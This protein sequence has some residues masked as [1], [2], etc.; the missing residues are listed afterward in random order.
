MITHLKKANP[1]MRK[2][3]EHTHTELIDHPLYKQITI[4]LIKGQQRITT[5]GRSDSNKNNPVTIQV[6]GMNNKP[7][8]HLYKKNQN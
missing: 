8:K 3:V 4:N 7:T 6:T 2:R 1:L 5:W